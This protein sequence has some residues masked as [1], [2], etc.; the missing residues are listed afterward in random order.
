MPSCLRLITYS[1][2]MAATLAFF[3]MFL[4]LLALI[5]PPMAAADNQMGRPD[6]IILSWTDDPYTTQT[7]AWRAATDTGQE[8]LQYLPVAGFNG[9]FTDAWEA[10]A[11]K[12]EL[13]AGYYHFETTLP[14]LSPNTRYIYRVGG[15]GAWSEPAFFTTAT[16]GD[17][18]TFVYMGD[19]QQG[20]EDWGKMLQ[21]MAAENPG[22]RFA[23]L[24]GD[25]VYDGNSKSEWEQFFTAATPTFKQIPLL[26]APGNHDDAP[27]FWNT[28]AL[29]QNGPE[30]FK[31]KFYSFDYGNCHI[32]VLDSNLMGASAAQ[33]NTVKT[34]LQNDLDS[35][36]KQWK[37]LAFH[38]PPYPVVEDGHSYN[39][40]V[41][42]V[43]LFEQCG[44]DVVFVGHQ[45]VYMRTKPLRSGQVQADG[46]G[47]VY[48]MGNAGTKFYPAGDNRDYIAK[49]LD[50][51]SSYQLIS[52][53]GDTF[54][55]SARD[56]DGQLIDSYTLGNLPSVGAEYSVT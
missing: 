51:I 50:Y 54:T 25:L 26:P 23:I 43:P 19:V 22:P 38:Y 7:V 12:T 17:Q 32:A 44:V 34:W 30:G 4:S 11:V 8:R 52:I 53:D 9:S 40:E 6:Q 37:F 46:E 42:W 45:H 39:L 49:E 5:N 1:N 16:P 14:N 47:I 27:L 33:Y 56:A 24:G 15:E 3:L 29:P 2:K 55:M 10:T 21:R 36:G 28:F 41:N 35:S 20:Y 31:E 18:F 13:Y 48:I